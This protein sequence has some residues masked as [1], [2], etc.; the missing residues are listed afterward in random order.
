MKLVFD[1]FLYGYLIAFTVEALDKYGVQKGLTILAHSY[2]VY[3]MLASAMTLLI[4]CL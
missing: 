1:V 4:R 3:S 2:M